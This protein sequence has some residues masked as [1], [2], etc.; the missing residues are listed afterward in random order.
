MKTFEE[1]LNLS[2]VNNHSSLK[3]DI[4]FA[5]KMSLGYVKLV[6]FFKHTSI[7]ESIFDVYNSFIK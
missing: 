4:Y 1:N 7:I 5:I 6:I 2:L 3:H